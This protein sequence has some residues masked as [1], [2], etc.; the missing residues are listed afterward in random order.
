[1]SLEEELAFAVQAY[2]SLVALCVPSEVMNWSPTDA[3]RQEYVRLCETVIDAIDRL[4][5]LE[6]RGLYSEGR[7]QNHIPAGLLRETREVLEPGEADVWVALGHLD[8]GSKLLRELWDAGS[9]LPIGGGRLRDTFEQGIEQVANLIDRNPDLGYENAYAPQAALEFL[10]SKL[11]GFQPDQWAGRASSLGPIRIGQSNLKLPGHVRLRIEELCRAYAF[12][13]WI[14][15]LSLCRSTLEYALLDNA[16]RLGI[17]TTWPPDRAGR[18]RAKRLSDLIESYVELRPELAT[19]MHL[20][21]D[22]G[23][24]YL[25]PR[26]S[27]VSKEALLRR[28]ADAEEALFTLLP[29]LESLYGAGR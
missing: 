13:C 20:V 2:R 9:V 29:L 18:C 11:I 8:L 6:S 1:M 14:A 24:E 27:Q 3:Q 16:G 23:N 17:E 7:I 28:S 15:V 26:Q 10:T 21:R 4:H 12:G 25:H 22:L 5:V 19:P